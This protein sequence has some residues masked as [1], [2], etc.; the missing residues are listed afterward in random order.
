MLTRI[1][2]ETEIIAMQ[3]SGKIL[4]ET[5]SQLE[6]E[7]RPGLA[8]ERLDQIANSFIRDHGATPTF[9]GYQGFP[10]S[11]CVSINDE[12][13]HGIPGAKEIKDGDVVGLDL[14]VTYHQMITDAAVTVGVGEIS[15]AA[16]NLITTTKQALDVAINSLKNGIKI[17]DIGAII[18]G[19]IKAGGLRVVEPLCGHG[20]GHDLHEDPTIFNFG[21]L[22]S[23]PTLKSGMTVAI[24]PIASISSSDMKIATDGWTCLTTDG[25][26]AAQF[27]HTVLIKDQGA[28]ILTV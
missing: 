3:H 12:I 5:L 1:K 9:L 15:D 16:K 14:G 25:S 24:E 13:V 6:K 17:G 18:E 28:Q 7:I 20:V 21:V 19:T 27:E 4:S 22:G 26:L 10:A 11:L 2:T 23:G 8:T